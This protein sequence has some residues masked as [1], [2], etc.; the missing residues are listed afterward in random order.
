[1]P[2]KMNCQQAFH[3]TGALWTVSLNTSRKLLQQKLMLGCDIFLA[4][5]KWVV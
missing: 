5:L 1:M 3:Q 4:T 2:L